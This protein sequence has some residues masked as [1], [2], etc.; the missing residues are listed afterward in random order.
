[1]DAVVPLYSGSKTEKCCK[2]LPR[3]VLFNKFVLYNRVCF[4][5]DCDLVAGD[6]SQY[7]H[8][9]PRSRKRHTVLDFFWQAERPCHF[10][11]LIFVEI[12]D[13]LDDFGKLHLKRHTTD[14]VMTLDT[15]FTL[16]AVRVDGSLQQASC[17]LLSCLAFEDPD[18]PFADCLALGFRIRNTFEGIKKFFSCI[19]NLEADVTKDRPDPFCLTFTHEAGV[20]IDWN[21]IISYRFGGK[22]GADR[23]VNSS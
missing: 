19:N 14:V 13:R 23:A 17:T 8:G 20:N 21:E 7:T 12:A 6:F 18:E 3:A 4:P 11:D 16:D 2:T 1:M 15:S 10:P 9:K 22:C 5:Y